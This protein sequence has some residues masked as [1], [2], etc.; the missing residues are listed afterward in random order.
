MLRKTLGVSK[1]AQARV[2]DIKPTNP[3]ESGGGGGTTGKMPDDTQWEDWSTL[4]D[5]IGKRDEL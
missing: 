1:S 2:D 3:N 5:K 4:K